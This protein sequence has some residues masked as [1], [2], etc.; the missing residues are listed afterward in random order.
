[1]SGVEF[2]NIVNELGLDVEKIKINKGQGLGITFTIIF[3][4]L[5]IQNIFFIS[6][7]F[8]LDHLLFI[9]IPDG[10]IFFRRGDFKI[11]IFIFFIKIIIQFSQVLRDIK[12]FTEFFQGALK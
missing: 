5:D 4:S 3:K 9:I 10:F 7:G 12:T 11:I 2:I 6:G 8:N 1:M